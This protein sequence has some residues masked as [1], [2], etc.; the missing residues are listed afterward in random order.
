MLDVTEE[1]ELSEIRR[2]SD[3]SRQRFLMSTR[4]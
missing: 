3:E 4:L 2:K 1:R